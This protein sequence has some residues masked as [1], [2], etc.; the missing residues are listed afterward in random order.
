[1]GEHQSEYSITFNG[2][3]LLVS[4]IRSS[5]YFTAIQF[6]AR[7]ISLSQSKWK[8]KSDVRTVLMLGVSNKNYGHLYGTGFLWQSNELV[9]RIRNKTNLFYV[10]FR[11]NSYYLLHNIF[12]SEFKKQIHDIDVYNYL[13]GNLNS[14]KT[15]SKQCLIP[16]RS[17][18]RDSSWL[19]AHLDLNSPRHFF[20]HD[21]V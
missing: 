8:V 9:L 16:L 5:I 2:L 17:H 14:G 15:K 19:W 10:C 4:I 7:P 21:K 18:Y 3:H 12:Y 11:F 13:V 1:M 6:Y 20:H